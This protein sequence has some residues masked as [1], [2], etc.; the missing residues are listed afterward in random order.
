MSPPLSTSSHSQQGGSKKKKNN[1]KGGKNLGGKTLTKIAPGCTWGYASEIIFMYP[2]AEIIVGPLRKV[3]F[4]PNS[5]S[6]LGLVC[7]AYVAWLITQGRFYSAIFW[8][9]LHGVLDAA[10]GTMAR[11]FNMCSP[12]G[13]ALDMN[14]DLLSG[15]LLVLGSLYISWGIIP[16]ICFELVY[17]VI[18]A[19]SSVLF[20]KRD[21]SVKY[22]EHLSWME[23]LGLISYENITYIVTILLLFINYVV[24][25]QKQDL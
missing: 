24:N 6:V 22:V 19:S 16:L 18:A 1:S 15:V 21:K 8:F 7:S 10:D 25:S 13:A 23:Y 17:T 12:F 5:I 3:G 2:I 20:D 11:R 14:C 9:A 4:T